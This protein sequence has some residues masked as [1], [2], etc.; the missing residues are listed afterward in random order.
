MNSSKGMKSIQ[1]SSYSDLVEKFEIEMSTSEEVTSSIQNKAE[2]KAVIRTENSDVLFLAERWFSLAHKH[3]HKRKQKRSRSKCERQNI[4]IK[5]YASAVSSISTRRSW[6]TA[7][8]LCLRLFNR[9][10][11]QMLHKHKKNGTCSFF[12]C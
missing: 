2:A 4:S 6:L 10:L 1:E 11:I 9:R 12:L 8:C 3:T 5:T 7:L